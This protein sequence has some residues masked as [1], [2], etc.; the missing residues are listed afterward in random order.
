MRRQQDGG[1]ACEVLVNLKSP[2]VV[3]KLKKFLESYEK[4]MDGNNQNNASFW[5][6][7]SNAEPMKNVYKLIEAYKSREVLGMLYKVATGPVRQR[8]QGNLN[9]EKYFWSNRTTA[10]AVLVAGTDQKHEDYK[11]KRMTMAGGMWTTPTEAEEDESVK[12]M[13]AW[14]AANAD[15]IVDTPMDKA[16]KEL[17]A[18]SQPAARKEEAAAP[19]NNRN[20]IIHNVQV[21]GG[22]VGGAGV[23]VKVHIGPA[24]V[25]QQD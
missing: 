17:P 18:A 15:K 6:Y 1:I 11:I 10:L 16:A 5:M 25:Q 20:V 24:G 9:N 2:Q 21:G 19:V 3:E 12:K 23:E 22:A 14:W 4:A 13:Q 7:N 8:S